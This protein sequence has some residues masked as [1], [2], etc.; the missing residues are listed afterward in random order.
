MEAAW[1]PGSQSSGKTD[2][3][4]YNLLG[5]KPRPWKHWLV[6]LKTL[7]GE[8]VL[9][10]SGR[11]GRNGGSSRHLT[12]LCVP[13]HLAQSSVITQST[14]FYTLVTCLFSL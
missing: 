9:E 1:P 8:S 14:F 11:R 6:S 10:R 2:S 12:L 13:P 7:P 4:E 3:K 5:L